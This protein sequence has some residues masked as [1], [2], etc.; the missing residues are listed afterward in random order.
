MRRVH[1]SFI[2]SRNPSSTTAKRG[3]E[4]VARDSSKNPVLA[5]ADE[6]R[7]A[8]STKIFSLPKIATQSPRKRAFRPAS[9]SRDDIDRASIIAMRELQKTPAAKAFPAILTIADVGRCAHFLHRAR[10]CCACRR[11]SASQRC[12]HR[13]RQHFLKRDA[14]FLNVLV[15]SG[16]SAFRFPSARSD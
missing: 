1:R 2:A 3:R 12:S 4:S 15:Y 11:C 6:T 7:S 9:V 16:C 5:S 8:V 10:A 13:A 14:V